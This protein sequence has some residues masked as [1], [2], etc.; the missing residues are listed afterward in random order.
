MESGEE[1]PSYEMLEQN[2]ERSDSPGCDDQLFN[3]PFAPTYEPTAEEFRDPTAYISKIRPQAELFGVCK[4]KPPKVSCIHY[5]NPNLCH[6][7][8]ESPTTA[9]CL[10]LVRKG[11]KK[12]QRVPLLFP[13]LAL[14]KVFVFHHWASASKSQR[15]VAIFQSDHYKQLEV[16]RF[17]S[18]LNVF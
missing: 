14:L 1:I 16:Y 7:L 3:F 13:Y 17:C 15:F 10:I 8:T 9:N 18:H 12:K 2:S 5:L 4:I 11:K 6:W